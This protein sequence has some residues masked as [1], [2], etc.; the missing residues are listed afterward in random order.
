M[1]EPADLSPQSILSVSCHPHIGS[2]VLFQGKLQIMNPLLRNFLHPL[3]YLLFL[4][5]L[6][7]KVLN[8]CP[9]LNAM[10]QFSYPCKTRLKLYF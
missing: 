9:C 8:I 7:R 1:P 4:V 3:Y 2:H 6:L 5:I 10:D